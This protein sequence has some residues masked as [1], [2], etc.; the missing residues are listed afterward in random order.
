MRGQGRVFRPKTRGRLTK[1]WWIDYGL[2]GARHREPTGTA[3]KAE[4]MRILREKITAREAGKV[5]G[6]AG[7]I[8]A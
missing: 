1:L 5:V 8:P 3:N 7:V 2:H 6:R 4:A